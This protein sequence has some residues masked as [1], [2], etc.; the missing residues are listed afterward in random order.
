MR[1]IRVVGALALT[2]PGVIAFQR[3]R[4]LPVDGIAGPRTRRALAETR[5]PSPHRD[6]TG[7]RANVSAHWAVGQFE[8]LLGFSSGPPGHFHRGGLSSMRKRC[9]TPTRYSSIGSISSGSTRTPARQAGKRISATVNGPSLPFS[10]MASLSAS[11]SSSWISETSRPTRRR[12]LGGLALVQW[13]AG[14][15][16]S[17]SG[18]GTPLRLRSTG[19]RARPFRQYRGSLLKE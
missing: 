17:T 16:S 4:G 9:P 13:S 5:A 1:P 14:R 18:G 12:Y 11:N 10:Q 15:S 8:R 19:R 2:R 3:R 6:P 7:S